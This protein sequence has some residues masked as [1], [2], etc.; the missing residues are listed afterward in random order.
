[1]LKMTIEGNTVTE[2]VQQLLNI[3][4]SFKGINFSAPEMQQEEIKPVITQ[5]EMAENMEAAPLHEEPKPRTL[6]EVRAILKD[7]RDKRGIAAVKELL[8]KFDAESVLNLKP[9][10]Y[11]EVYIT[12]FTEVG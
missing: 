11:D 3:I 4:G 10:D 12:A 8:K 1:M 2:L 5:E 9:E 6:E 7:L